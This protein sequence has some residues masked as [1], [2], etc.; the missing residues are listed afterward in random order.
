MTPKK[1]ETILKFYENTALGMY[2]GLA[3]RMADYAKSP[4]VEQKRLAELFESAT[5]TAGA[6]PQANTIPCLEV[7]AISRSGRLPPIGAPTDEPNVDLCNMLSLP[8]IGVG[9]GR[10]TGIAV[11][12]LVRQGNRRCRLRRRRRSI[13]VG[14]QGR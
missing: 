5:T 11:P 13:L 9:W 4:H 2:N 12:C 8:W 1:R 14:F 6:Q 3:K 7:A 10:A